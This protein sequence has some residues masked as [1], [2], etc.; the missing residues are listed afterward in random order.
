MGLF[1]G[2]GRWLFGML[3]CEGEWDCVV[4]RRKVLGMGSGIC[5][6]T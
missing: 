1:G 3:M 5:R 4:E 6:S 2:F